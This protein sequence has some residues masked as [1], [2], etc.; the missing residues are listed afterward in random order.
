VGKLELCI[1]SMPGVIH[2]EIVCRNRFEDP[3]GDVVSFLFARAKA[4]LEIAILQCITR[5]G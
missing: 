3:E 1:Y 4:S 2:S 5:D